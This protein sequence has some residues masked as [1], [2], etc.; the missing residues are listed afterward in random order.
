MLW[1]LINSHDL[2]W[3]WKSICL[4]DSSWKRTLMQII[5]QFYTFSFLIKWL[6]RH[7]QTLWLI[8]TQWTHLYENRSATLQTLKT[9][10]PHTINKNEKKKNIWNFNTKQSIV[11]LSGLD[12]AL[13]AC[14]MHY[15]VVFLHVNDSVKFTLMV[16]LGL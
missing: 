14:C 4:L 8:K 2:Q 5:I 10:S 7:R 6:K 9:K 13:H 1:Y 11:S 16:S 12:D 3:F 15:A